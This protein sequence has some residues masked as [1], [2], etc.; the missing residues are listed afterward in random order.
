MSDDLSQFSMMDLFLMEAET[1]LQTLTQG[2]LE[3][4]SNPSTMDS[5]DELMRAAHSIKGAARIVNIEAAVQ[6][7]HSMEDGF[8]AVQNKETTLSNEDIDILLKGVDLLKALSETPEKELE[9]WTKEQSTEIQKLIEQL[10][11]VKSSNKTKNPETDPLPIIPASESLE[12][13]SEPLPPLHSEA[14]ENS[15]PGKATEQSKDSTAH[16]AD[17]EKS[18]Q[19]SLLPDTSSSSRHQGEKSSIRITGENLNRLMELGAESLVEAKRLEPIFNSLIQLKSHQNALESTIEDLRERTEES[20]DSKG[21]QSSMTQV[22]RALDSLKKEFFSRLSHLEDYHRRTSLISDQLYHQVLATRMRPFGDGLTAYPRMVRDISRQLGKM[23]EFSIRGKETPVDRDTLEKLDAPINHMVRNALDHGLETGEERKAAGKPEKGSL[24]IQAAHQSGMLRITLSDD[25]RGID[26][27]DLKN[28][29]L[30]RNLA[31]AEMVATMRD[32]E[33]LEFLFLP[34]F[35]TADKVTDISGRGVGLDVVQ[36]MVQKLGGKT[37]ITTQ[38]GLGTTFHLQ[39]PVS[40]SVMRSLLVEISGEVYAVPLSRTVH[41]VKL[42]ANEILSAEGRQFFKWDQKNVGLIPAWQV[43]ELPFPEISSGDSPVIIL[44]DHTHLYGLTVDR[45]LGE[46]DLV[47]RPLYP[48]LGQAPDI[49]AAAIGEDGEPVLILDVDDLVRSIENLL[50]TGRLRRV[51]SGSQSSGPAAEK[52][53]TVL[54]VDDSITVRELQRQ[55]LETRGYRVDLAM[56]GVEGWNAL[57]LGEYD[58]V[59]TAVDMPRMTGIELLQKI[60][61]EEHLKQL[62]VIIVSYKDRE[63]DKLQG[64]DAGADYYLTKSSFHDESYLNAITELIG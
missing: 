49:S 43:L 3:L 35:S 36:T 50:T 31:A 2:L 30:E 46:E 19:P 55:L 17:R 41:A 14:K 63:E 10:E 40:R 27:N 32:H 1:H 33:L 51:P 23:V 37:Q 13:V 53:K 22:F 21:I 61:S 7:A 5:I 57:R 47:V 20:A 9:K 45:F 60:R 58:L 28:K 44:S 59:V 42:T 54:V 52:F 39:L 64:M 38:A 6:I 18:N 11:S 34:S 29:I 8:V 48:R 25:G 4:E 26:L 16:R 12:M 24:K 15:P 56:D 62:P